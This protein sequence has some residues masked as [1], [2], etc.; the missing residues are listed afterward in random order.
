MYFVFRGF[1]PVRDGT[2]AAIP[3]VRADTVTILCLKVGSDVI[4][5]DN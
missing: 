2:R 4:I 3:T 5:I 1:L